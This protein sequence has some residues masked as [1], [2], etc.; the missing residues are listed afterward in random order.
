[1]KKGGVITALILIV[2]AVFLVVSARDV[3]DRFNPLVPKEDVFVRV[4][5]PAKPDQGRFK[6]ELTGY[7]AEGKKKK[8][9]FTSSIQL[10][11]GTYLKVSAKGAYTENYEKIAE[12]EVP[13]GIK[14]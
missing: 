4:N 5:K 9:T 2:L 1:M 3:V 6:Y 13:K 12:E 7:N 8:V 14:W 10:P 11:E